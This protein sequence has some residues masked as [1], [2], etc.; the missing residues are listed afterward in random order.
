MPQLAGLG[1][2]S[3]LTQ[4]EELVVLRSLILLKQVVSS[5]AAQCTSPHI[6]LC[7]SANREVIGS[8]LFR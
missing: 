4:G 1:R 6:S 5:A 2:Y 3:S 8:Q 7:L